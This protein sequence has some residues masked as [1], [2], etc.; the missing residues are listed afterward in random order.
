MKATS[1]YLEI[2]LREQLP[3]GFKVTESATHLLVD[4]QVDH[5]WS[6][7]L[8]A[9]ES[10]ASLDEQERLRMLFESYTATHTIEFNGEY[11]AIY[12]WPRKSVR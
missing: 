12:E 1:R 8:M 11:V 7:V 9:L 2:R 6:Q 10:C 3:E 5:P 4:M